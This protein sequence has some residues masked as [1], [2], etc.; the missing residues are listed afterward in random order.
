MKIQSEAILK[1]ETIRDF[2]VSL[3]CCSWPWLEANEVISSE[4]D[5]N[6]LRD[7]LQ[8]FANRRDRNKSIKPEERIKNWIQ[9]FSRQNS[10]MAVK[11]VEFLFSPEAEALCLYS[12]I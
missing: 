9:Y 2:I 10:G 6:P 12:F 1:T 11:Q 7:W 8:Y 3:L 4:Q 5:E